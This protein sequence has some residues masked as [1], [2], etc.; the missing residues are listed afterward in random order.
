M[1]SDALSLRPQSSLP[2][3]LQIGSAEC[4]IVI[5]G[6]DVSKAI[7]ELHDEGP[8]RAASCRC[9]DQRSLYQIQVW[10]LPGGMTGSL[11]AAVCQTPISSPMN[12]PPV[13]GQPTPTST[14]RSLSRYRIGPTRACVASGACRRTEAARCLAASLLGIGSN[15]IIASLLQKGQQSNPSGFG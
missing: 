5:I 13:S 14:L 11:G 3:Q 8:R 15:R 10:R 2:E 9:C 4:E 12:L 1:T 7:F 6:F